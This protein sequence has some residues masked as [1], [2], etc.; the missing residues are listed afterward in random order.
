[1]RTKGFHEKKIKDV[2][3]KLYARTYHKEEREKRRRE[4][5]S[6]IFKNIL[7]GKKIEKNIQWINPC[8]I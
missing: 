7:S 1:M 8:R 5:G 4:F 2:V 6:E 3:E